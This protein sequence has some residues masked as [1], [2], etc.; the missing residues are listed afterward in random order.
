M[1]LN[2]YFTTQIEF[3]RDKTSKEPFDPK[4]QIAFRIQDSGL[5]SK[6]GISLYAG[7]G[8]AD[9]IRGDHVLIAPPYNTTKEEIVLIAELAQKVIEDVFAE[10]S[11]SA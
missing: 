4:L 2:P 8:T 3:V 11:T 1:L 10:A 5:S 9:G 6:Y 7:Q